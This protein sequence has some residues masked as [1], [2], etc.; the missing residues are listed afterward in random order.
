[1]RY[2]ATLALIIIVLLTSCA[3]SKVNT[4]VEKEKIMSGSKVYVMQVLD[5]LY[6][7]HEYK[8]SGLLVSNKVLEAVKTVQPS[9]ELTDETNKSK[10]IETARENGI[11]YVIEPVLE[12]WED[13][14]NVWSGKQDKIIIV[15]NVTRVSD[16]N[17]VI[18]KSFHAFSDAY[19]LVNTKPEELLEINFV[20]F[21]VSLFEQ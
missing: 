2:S 21:V 12:H 13:R 8:G 19:P 7:A 20:D 5:G 16:S 11:H 6:G 9:A 3:H 10:A 15:L 18:S 14:L 4:A 17:Q 1:M